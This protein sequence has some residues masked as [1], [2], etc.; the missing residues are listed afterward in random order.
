MSDKPAPERKDQ[1][2]TSSRLARFAKM[3]GL[4]A[5][6]TAR[7]LGQKLVGAFQ[8]DEQKQRALTD[9][10]KRSAQQIT[11]TL[12]EL[13]GA[14]MKVGQL[15][16]TDPELLPKEMV[17]EIASLQHSAPPMSFS[18][19]KGVIEEALGQPLEAVFA[20]FSAE[21]VGA[22]SIGQVHRATTIDGHDV[23]VKVQYPGIRDTIESDV[24]NLGSLLTV[25]RVNLP[26]DRVD[27]YLTEF[28]EVIKAESDYVKEAHNLERFGAMFQQIPGIRVPRPLHELTRDNVL[29]MTF[30]EGEKLE[31]WLSE[32][33]QS[34]KD[35]QGKRLL[36]VFLQS[37]H[38]NHV[39]NADPHP[40][41]F[42]VLSSEPHEG[43]APPLGLLDAGCV[44][45]FSAEFTDNLIRF[46]NAMWR[47][48]LESL[49]AITQA[50]GFLH[51]PDID[52]EDIYEWNELILAPLL[53]DREWDFG[54]WKI[55]EQAVRF[56]LAHP[57]MRMWS[58]P[59]EILFY[60]RTLVGM[61]GLLAK[62][63]V[64]VN[65]YRLAKAM[66]EERGIIR[67]RL[68]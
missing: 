9:A 16:A 49:Q 34:Q 63:G 21:P 59:R 23:A 11:K 32:A 14:A 65:V 54:A 44:R 67:R 37:V 7:H 18:T 39:L 41:N 29:V 17:D 19:V 3:S 13:K 43:G 62:T 4:T 66:A 45:T 50:L 47:H 2:P 31:R 52:A 55:Q 48:D 20:S 10:Q 6:V 22:A 68:R 25:L 58:P 57:N 1:G 26:K 38:R 56:M 24:G 15:M 30:L 5:G 42:V 51:S 60:V 53:D 61:R 27:A 40:G 28:K 35:A 8:N 36:D 64:R 46:M 33:P 12:G